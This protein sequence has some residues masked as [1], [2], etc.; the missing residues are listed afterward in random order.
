M[1]NRRSYQRR[2][3]TDR[4]EEMAPMAPAIAGVIFMPTT[5]DEIGS[6]SLV[7]PLD[8]FELGL[9]RAQFGCI[10][11]ESFEQVINAG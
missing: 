6:V 11:D 1:A 3:A 9:T 8:E 10:G 5:A 7:G 2:L 4:I